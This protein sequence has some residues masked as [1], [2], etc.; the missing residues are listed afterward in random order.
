MA[1]SRRRRS[2]RWPGTFPGAARTCTRL[3]YGGTGSTLSAAS[4]CTISRR[5]TRRRMSSPRTSM[6]SG[7]C[8]NSR[9][10]AAKAWRR[11]TAPWAS[12]SANESSRPSA[13]VRDRLVLPL[14]ALNPLR[15]PLDRAHQRVELPLGRH[16]AADET[17]EHDLGARPFVDRIVRHSEQRPERRVEFLFLHPGGFSSPVPDRPCGEKFVQHDRHGMRQVQNRIFLGGGNRDEQVAPPQFVVEQAEVLPTEQQRDPSVFLRDARC[18][19]SRSQRD[20][21]EALLALRVHAGR[22]DRSEEH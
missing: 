7:P 21:S 4:A 6:R 3:P 11:R 22:S 12:E 5:Y 14:Q 16:R 18:G 15:C 13:P 9:R 2:W 10:T 20:S 17:P 8:S 1:S 19:L